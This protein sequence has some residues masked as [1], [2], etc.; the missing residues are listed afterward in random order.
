LQVFDADAGIGKGEDLVVE[1]DGEGPG[2]GGLADFEEQVGVGAAPFAGVTDKGGN[3]IDERIRR[4]GSVEC[5]ADL[6][7]RAVDGGGCGAR[8][9]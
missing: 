5:V 3:R 4:R 1:F 6:V 7:G 2:V 9:G 8:P